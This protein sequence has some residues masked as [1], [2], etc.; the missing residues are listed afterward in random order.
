MANELPLNNKRKIMS[1]S[2]IGLGDAAGLFFIILTVLAVLRGQ[3]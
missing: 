2:I 3:I 1:P